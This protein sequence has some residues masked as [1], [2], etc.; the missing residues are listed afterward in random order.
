M[1]APRRA[2]SIRARDYQDL[3]EINTLAAIK[4]QISDNVCSNM[5]TIFFIFFCLNMTKE[6]NCNGGSQK[7]FLFVGIAVKGAIVIPINI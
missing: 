3:S 1:N 4:K 7:W 6:E 2:S 5:I